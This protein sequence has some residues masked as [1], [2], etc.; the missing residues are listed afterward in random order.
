MENHRVTHPQ[1]PVDRPL[2]FDSTRHPFGHPGLTP[3][4]TDTDPVAEDG[5][6]TAPMQDYTVQDVAI[7]LLVLGGGLG[8]AYLVPGMV[9]S[10]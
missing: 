3:G 2:Y 1:G 5:R 10:A 4:M 7:G 8:I 6:V 9:A